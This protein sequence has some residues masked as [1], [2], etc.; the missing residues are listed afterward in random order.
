MKAT[1]AFRKGLAA[2]TVVSA[3]R[4]FFS[5]QEYYPPAPFR[6]RRELVKTHPATFA[7]LFGAINGNTALPHAEML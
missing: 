5:I 7:V 3:R 2:Q 6:V 4:S 1:I